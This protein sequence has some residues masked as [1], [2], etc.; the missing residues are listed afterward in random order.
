VTDFYTTGITNSTGKVK[1]VDSDGKVYDVDV[2][3]DIAGD[4]KLVIDNPR[5]LDLLE[6]ILTTLKKIEYHL[7]LGT[8]TELKD[9][10]VGG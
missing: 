1:F 7:F 4:Y 3:E 5:G 9:Q 8:E 2:K 6:Q 10:D